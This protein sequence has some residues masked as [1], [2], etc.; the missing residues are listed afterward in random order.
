MKITKVRTA[1]I[2]GN[3]P[4]VLVRIE[5]D[6]GI[7]GLGEAYWGAAIPVARRRNAF[8]SIN[9]ETNRLEPK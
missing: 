2:D 6:E 1:V 4:W 3:L 7:T 8:T 9:I 5:T